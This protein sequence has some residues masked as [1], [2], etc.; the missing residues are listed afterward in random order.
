MTKVRNSKGAPLRHAKTARD[1]RRPWRIDNI[2]PTSSRSCATRLRGWS[3]VILL[4]SIGFKSLP[5]GPL[6]PTRPISGL[7]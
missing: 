7:V 2:S 6:L 3:R 1:R 4:P 5:P